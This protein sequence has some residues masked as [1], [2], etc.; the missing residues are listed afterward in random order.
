MMGYSQGGW[1]TLSAFKTLEEN[2]TTGLNPVAASCGAGAYNLVD[3]AVDILSRPT[4]GSPVYLPYFI[5]SH[6]RNGLLNTSLSLYF[7]KP[8][9]DSI[10]KLFNGNRYLGTINNGLNDTIARLMTPE[11]IRN[12]TTDPSF[13]PLRSELNANSV[14]PWPLQG[15][16]LF[17]H[18]TADPVVPVSESQ[19]IVT[20]FR[21]LGADE[22]KVKLI[23]LEGADHSSGVLPW[24]L[25]SLVWLDGL[26]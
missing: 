19:N 5:E 16:L 23:L 15:K 20:E 21:A 1:A 12:F 6:Q 8:Y 11:I 17:V 13:E 18:G 4:Y 2:N 26:K 14:F 3:V 9:L 7:N 25:K 24:A 10:P 22:N